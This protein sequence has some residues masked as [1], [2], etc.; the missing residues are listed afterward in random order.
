MIE[1]TLYIY[2]NRAVLKNG[3]N[4]FKKKNNVA[5]NV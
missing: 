4:L 2:R 5:L 3:K 1:L